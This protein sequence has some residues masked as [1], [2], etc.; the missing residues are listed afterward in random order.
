MNTDHLNQV[1]RRG[2]VR[3]AGASAA[4][5]YLAQIPC[6]HGQERPLVTQREWRPC[7][8][9]GQGQVPEVNVDKPVELDQLPVRSTE[10]GSLP[11]PVDLALTEQNEDFESEEAQTKASQQLASGVALAQQLQL[12]ASA[13]ARLAAQSKWRTSELK[14]YFYPSSGSAPLRRR[15][16]EIAE[17]WSKVARMDFK[18]TS[19][20]T[21]GNIRIAFQGTGHWSYVG[22]DSLNVQGQTMNLQMNSP[23]SDGEY[24][25]GV[26]LHEFGHALGCIHEHQ[27]PG[28]EGLFREQAVIDYYRATYGWDRNKTVLNVLRRYDRT[29]LLRG[30]VSAFDE[31]SIMLYQYPAELT[32]NGRGTP[33][34]T[35]LSAIDRQ[36]IAKLYPGRTAVGGVVGTKDD[37]QVDQQRVLVVNGP[38]VPGAISPSRR[39][40][41]Y[42][43]EIGASGTYTLS[44]H[45][46]T[47]VVMTLR[48]ADGTLV[49]LTYKTADSG[50]N[51]IASPDLPAGRYRLEIRHRYGGGVGEYEV[52]VKSGD[53]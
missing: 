3:T 26:V 11:L 12:P 51:R 1:S 23:P 46:Y 29:Q 10:E 16:R 33:R 9:V 32:R 41:S 35:R 20:R 37:V 47:Q 39:V 17:E 15:V 49:D 28:A 48:R 6:A 36:Y 31:Q 45:G 27:S 34:N 25:Y 52:Q 14:I 18:E 50:I 19:T 2:F 4:G 22:I 8:D 38:R 13:P 53:R 44:T 7:I 24:N 42:E 43:M 21:D 40:N 5:A 30:M